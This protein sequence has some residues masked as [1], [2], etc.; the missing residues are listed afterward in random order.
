MELAVAIT[1]FLL[2][3][4]GAIRLFIWLNQTMVFRQ[5]AYE[6]TRVNATNAT[7]EY[8]AMVDESGIPNLH[9][10]GD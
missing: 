2:L 1:C 5:E 9:I 7:T 4:L 6:S 8:Q 3:L 10:V